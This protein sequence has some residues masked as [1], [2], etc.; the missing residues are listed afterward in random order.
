MKENY[1]S[2]NKNKNILYIFIKINS[3]I[4]NKSQIINFLKINNK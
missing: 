1:Y 3:K 2:L 4:S